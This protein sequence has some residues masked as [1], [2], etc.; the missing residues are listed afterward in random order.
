MLLVGMRVYLSLTAGSG[1]CV[2]GW[3][4]VDAWFTVD[5]VHVL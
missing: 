3:F 4:S 1:G 2:D 5:A